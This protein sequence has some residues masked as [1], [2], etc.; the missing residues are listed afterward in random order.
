MVEQVV[1]DTKEIKQI[2]DE[3]LEN[4]YDQKNEYFSTIV[5][6]FSLKS[7]DE[8]VD[9]EE[10]IQGISDTDQIETIL[11]TTETKDDGGVIAM[12]GFYYQ[13]LVTIEYLVDMIQGK[14]SNIVVDHH[15]D[16]IAYNDTT[17]RFIQVKTK[18]AVHCPVSKTRAYFEWIP[19]LF[20][21][22]NMFEGCDYKI[23]F[24]LVS[25][26]IF[27]EAPQSCTDFEQFYTNANFE[28][29]F[30]DGDLFKRVY[31]N[32][33]ELNLDE[34]KVAKGIKGFKVRHIDPGTIRRLL[35]TRIGECFNSYYRADDDTIDM[36]VAYLF[37][38]CYFPKSA[39]IQIVRD[40]D[41]EEL[42]AKIRYRIQM[43]GEKDIVCNSSIEVLGG[44]IEYTKEQ[45]KQTG[46]YSE[47]SILVEEFERELLLYFQNS[48]IETIMTLVNKYLNKSL[49]SSYFRP[50]KS[51]RLKKESGR[52]FS[53]LLLVK[54]YF[55]GEIMIDSQSKKLLVVNIGGHPFNLF[56]VKEELA[57]TI[58]DAVKEF[59]QV[60][61][62]LEFEEQFAIV[63]NPSFKIILSGEYDNDCDPIES[64]EVFCKETPQVSNL[65]FPSDFNDDSIAKVKNII[66]VVD[67]EDNKINGIHRKRMRYT[68]I[69]KMRESI[70]KEL[71]FGEIEQV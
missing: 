19:K 52:L 35:Y 2:V 68:N 69:D 14:W 10:V 8:G 46:A 44:F 20:D 36:I 16:I 33:G 28:N 51:E 53:V 42:M 4:S 25:N 61:Q 31:E 67:G 21:N 11:L 30:I 40:E 15:Q 34:D 56:G 24:E 64:L 3:L 6:K 32:I 26:C 38:K 47:I 43:I 39:S 22:Q 63:N 27:R 70:G 54:L 17:V 50:S 71:N 45:Y 13:L 41:L 60:F 5:D 58:G 62:S 59:E 48:E 29:G 49:E 7:N 37:K 66:T 23:E 65:L 55:G 57:C 9:I 12:S 1:D 18:N